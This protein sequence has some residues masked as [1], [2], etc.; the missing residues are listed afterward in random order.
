MPRRANALTADCVQV[1]DSAF[2]HSLLNDMDEA[3]TTP[4]RATATETRRSARRVDERSNESTIA[5]DM[6][7][8]SLSKGMSSFSKVTGRYM[9]VCMCV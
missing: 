2:P 7:E 6:V 9:C 4:S 5:L 3:A 1:E 8:K